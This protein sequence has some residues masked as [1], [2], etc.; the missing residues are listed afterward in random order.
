MKNITFQK[1][2][3][4]RLDKFLA[5]DLNDFSRS[6]I[7]KMIKDG[8]ITINGQAVKPHCFLKKGDKIKIEKSNIPAFAIAASAGR[9]MVVPEIIEETDDYL[10]INKPAG[11]IVHPAAG[12]KEKTLT[13]WLLEKYPSVQSVGDDPNRPGIVHRLDKDVSG[14]IVIAKTKTM[15]EHLKKQFQ[16]RLI[17]KEYLALARGE[18]KAAEGIIDLPLKRSRRSG[19]MA[20]QPKGGEGKTAITEFSV[21][22]KFKNYTYLKI[23][24][25]TGRSHQIRTHFFAYGYP[26]VGDKLYRNKKI[27]EKIKL[28]RIFLHAASLAFADLENKQKE[29]HC[30]LPG[31]LND[32]L[33]KLK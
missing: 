10:V 5:S 19:K 24:L 14:L 28:N 13:D 32:I 3:R 8:L 22:K 23:N 20:A 25:K 27:K 7:Q 29:Y 31:E 21:I 12:I 9:Q 2:L 33:T 6:Q 16:E 17:K 1:E 18:I 30:P 4:E 11:L 26:L 15:F